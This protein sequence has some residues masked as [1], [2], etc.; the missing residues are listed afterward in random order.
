MTE[1]H[2]P[3]SSA[4]STNWNHDFAALAGSLR[5]RL[6]HWKRPALSVVQFEPEDFFWFAEKLA[7]ERHKNLRKALLALS[8]RVRLGFRYSHGRLIVNV[9]GSPF[10]A[11]GCSPQI[12]L[13]IWRVTPRRDTGNEWRRNMDQ[14]VLAPRRGG[15]HRHTPYHSFHLPAPCVPVPSRLRS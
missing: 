1:Q 7:D 14:H 12:T 2:K 9:R 15:Q 3:V 13:D 6:H 8:G 11:H 4:M 5:P 10:G